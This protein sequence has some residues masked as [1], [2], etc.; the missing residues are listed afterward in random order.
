MPGLMSIERLLRG[1]R[2]LS[3]LLGRSSRM[4]LWHDFGQGRLVW[5]DRT[6]LGYFLSGSF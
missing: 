2:L 1:E 6:L 4:W 5:S 3:K